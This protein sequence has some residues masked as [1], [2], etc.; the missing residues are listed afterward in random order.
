MSRD[1]GRINRA[2]GHRCTCGEFIE[3]VDTPD[4]VVWLHIRL[5]AG[6]DHEARPA[7]GAR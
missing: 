4:G 3:Q 5:S 2:G 7:G 6:D 1:L